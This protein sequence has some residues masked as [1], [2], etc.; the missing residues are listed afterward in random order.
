[1]DGWGDDDDIYCIFEQQNKVRAAD[2]SLGVAA[3]ARPRPLDEV[4]VSSLF[5][6]SNSSKVVTWRGRG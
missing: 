1:M 2:I 6:T 4:I 3:R 5:S